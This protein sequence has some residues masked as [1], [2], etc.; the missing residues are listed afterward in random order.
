ML[1]LS[2]MYAQ[3]SPAPS[4][5]ATI[6]LQSKEANLR[7]DNKSIDAG[8]K[9]AEQQASNL[10]SAATTGMVMGIL[11]GAATIG[12]AVDA[13]ASA[14]NVLRGP[15]TTSLLDDLHFFGDSVTPERRSDA[16]EVMIDASEAAIDA[17]DAAKDASTAASDRRKTGLD[18]IQ[19][20]LDILRRMNPQL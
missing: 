17:A 14:G 15:P 7:S 1:G 5:A 9:E 4:T 19:K 18:N 16:T 20:L 12:S 6:T 11:S 2:F 3:T 10:M 8:M 13:T